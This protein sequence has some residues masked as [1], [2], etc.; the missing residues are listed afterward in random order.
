MR[1]K[2]RICES[3]L[4]IHSIRWGANNWN[5]KHP[6]WMEYIAKRLNANFTDRKRESLVLDW[7]G[8]M[9]KTV[10]PLRANAAGTN[11]TSGGSF[12]NYQLQFAMWV[13]MLPLTSPNGIRI[14]IRS[15]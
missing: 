8:A 5:Q 14:R 11:F 1:I 3:S 6:L 15:I 12:D 10:A 4:Q 7:E 2:T 9:I 13:S